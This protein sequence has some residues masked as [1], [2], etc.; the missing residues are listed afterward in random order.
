V[1]LIPQRIGKL[2]I[3]PCIVNAYI[4]GKNS[5]RSFFGYTDLQ[6]FKLSS[7]IETLIV[8]NLPPSPA[9]FSG[10]V[11]K[12]TIEANSD[13]KKLTTDEAVS[14][15]VTIQGN[16]DKSLI[17]NPTLTTNLETEIYDAKVIEEN[18]KVIQGELIHLKKL[19]YLV[20]PKQKGSLDI[21]V[22]FNYFDTE[23]NSYKDAKTQI[24]S[25][26][27][28]QGNSQENSKQDTSIVAK[29]PKTNKAIYLIVFALL[30]I[31]AFLGVRKYTAEK[32]AK[33]DP[34]IRNQ[35]LASKK[36]VKHLQYAKSKLDKGNEKEF[37]SVLS[38][39]LNEYIFLKFNI[40]TDQQNKDYIQTTIKDLHNA[41]LAERYVALM[42]ACE[43]AVYGF[44]LQ[45]PAMEYY[46]EARS[47][48]EGLEKK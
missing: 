45:K 30:T 25:V 37:Y 21:Q 39:S 19:E 31:I 42:N 28:S 35:N 12:Y 32:A 29:E 24:I 38:A 14:V 3:E 46:E 6:N 8:K 27:V 22:A 43:S 20:V 11:G 1:L 4:A 10:A 5:E 13:K 40:A 47:I 26:S 48:L 7:Q 41:E 36:I 17:K 15:F 44:G 23:E 16:G 33:I 18:E 2:V 9:H 34:I